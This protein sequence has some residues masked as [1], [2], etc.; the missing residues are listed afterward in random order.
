MQNTAVVLGVTEHEIA[1]AAEQA[2]LLT[3][4]VTVIGARRIVER[5]VT[6]SAFIVLR[7][8]T[9]FNHFAGESDL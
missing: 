4:Y 8:K 5:L 2:A 9:R 1:L 6:N 7:R 3:R